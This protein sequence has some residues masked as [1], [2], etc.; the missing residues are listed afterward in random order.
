MGQSADALME[1]REVDEKKCA[2]IFQEANCK[3]WI[4]RCKA[5]MDN[6]QEQQRYVDDV[7]SEGFE[8]LI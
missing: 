3:T 6:F 5:K 2:A 1:L 7:H 4:F 8:F